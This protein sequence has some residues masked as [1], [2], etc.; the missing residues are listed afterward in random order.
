MS[1]DCEK[2][3]SKEM[4]TW[5]RESGILTG[6]G[7]RIRGYLSDNLQRCVSQVVGLGCCCGHEWTLT[8]RRLCFVCSDHMTKFPLTVSQQLH[9]TFTHHSTS[10]PRSPSAESPASL[11]RRPLR[12]PGSDIRWFR[13]TQVCTLPAWPYWPVPVHIDVFYDWIYRTMVETYQ[14]TLQSS[15]P[16]GTIKTSNPNSFHN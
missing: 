14:F 11:S 16:Q 13:Y 6:R 8:F 5:R 3:N 2:A 10:S 7:R 15:H 1:W 9:T 4:L 12:I